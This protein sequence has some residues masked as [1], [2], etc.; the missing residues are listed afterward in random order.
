MENNMKNK[1]FNQSQL[2]TYRNVKKFWG[3]EAREKKTKE[4]FF[5]PTSTIRDHFFRLHDLHTLLSFIPYESTLLD[6]G[7]GTG[8]STLILN[9]KAGFTTGIDYSKEMIKSAKRLSE[10]QLYRKYIFSKFGYL[11]KYPETRHIK[12]YVG[13]AL[14]GFRLPPIKNYFNGKFIIDFKG[15]IGTF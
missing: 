2:R 1:F 3:A 8:F 10:D 4:G 9:T 7:C 15:F 12:F 5:L 13:D 6:I 14:K 11:Y